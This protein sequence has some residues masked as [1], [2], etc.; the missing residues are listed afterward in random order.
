M[1]GC[2][3]LSSKANAARALHLATNHAAARFAT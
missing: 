2:E 3:V 1:S